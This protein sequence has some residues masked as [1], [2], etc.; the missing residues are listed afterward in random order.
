MGRLYGSLLVL[1]LVFSTAVSFFALSLH[2]L[3]WVWAVVGAGIGVVFLALG[4]LLVP[5]ARRQVPPRYQKA[6]NWL[7]QF[8]GAFCL[9]EVLVMGLLGW[10]VGNRSYSGNNA[11]EVLGLLIFLALLG[12]GVQGMV[13]TFWR[14]FSARNEVVAEERAA[15]AAQLYHEGGQASHG[16]AGGEG[17]VHA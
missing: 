5:S 4:G 16:S 12:G 11:Y 7:L 6:A 10:V 1:G 3:D 2:T 13:F 14:F 8:F 15:R 9:T 17:L